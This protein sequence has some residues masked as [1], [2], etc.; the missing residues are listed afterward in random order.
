[1]CARDGAQRPAV[2]AQSQA[3]MG[4]VAKVLASSGCHERTGGAAIGASCVLPRWP[5]G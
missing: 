5:V 1:M 4:D 2:A 3:A